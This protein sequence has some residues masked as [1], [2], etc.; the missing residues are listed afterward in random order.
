MYVRQNAMVGITRSKVISYIA[1]I[2]H[3]FWMI[4]MHSRYDLELH[5]AEITK[6]TF[7][8]VSWR[9][10][11]GQGPIAARH[12]SWARYFPC[13]TPWFYWFYSDFPCIWRIKLDSMYSIQVPIATVHIDLQT[14]QDPGHWEPSHQAILP[15]D[16]CSSSMSESFLPSDRN[17]FDMSGGGGDDDDVCFNGDKE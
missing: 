8:V 11:W 14:S 3:S 13:E 15:Q 4:F 17:I 12:L 6:P 1:V 5:G 7:P 16:F 10:I 2:T 9:K